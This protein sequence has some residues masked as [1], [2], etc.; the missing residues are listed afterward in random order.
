MCIHLN[1]HY[2]NYHWQG[3][4]S[5]YV[6]RRGQNDLWMREGKK[7]KKLQSGRTNGGDAA[8]L[9]RGHRLYLRVSPNEDEL[10]LR[11]RGCARWKGKQ[12]PGGKWVIIYVAA[13]LKLKRKRFKKTVQ[14][15]RCA[16]TLLSCLL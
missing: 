5:K 9:I 7:K 2:R 1:T 10:S 8:D 4:I 15:K 12:A 16:K 14:I 13:R 6:P 11:A 3:E